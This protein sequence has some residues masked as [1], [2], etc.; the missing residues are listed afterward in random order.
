[1]KH[2]ILKILKYT[3][4]TFGVCFLTTALIISGFAAYCHHKTGII[5]AEQKQA[6][7]DFL[8]ELHNK[9]DSKRLALQAGLKVDEPKSDVLRITVT[10]ADKF[11]NGGKS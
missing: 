11:L 8:F 2:R 10:P 3:A 6:Y 5:R 9:E 1:M 4:I 7:A